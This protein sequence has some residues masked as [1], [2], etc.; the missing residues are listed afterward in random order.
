MKITLLSNEYPPYVYGGAGVHVE[1]L[2]KALSAANQVDILC[3][4]DQNVKDGALS[5]RG[6]RPEV[7][8][9]SQNAQFGKLIDT[10]AR[11]VMMSGTAP[12]VI[13]EIAFW[14]SAAY[15]MMLCSTLLPLAFS[16]SP[17]IFLN[18]M[19]SSWAKPWTHQTSI[20][21]AAALATC[22]RGRVPSAPSA[23]ELRRTERRV[24]MAICVS[25]PVGGATPLPPRSVI[26][27]GGI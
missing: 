23:R 25:I 1:Y 7:A 8:L 15:G 19:S 26:V 4:G 14:R 16:Y 9:P 24:R 10:L 20:V 17:T 11:D 27:A 12:L 13:A 18:E 22:G 21:V 3:F 2:S 5:V 6:I